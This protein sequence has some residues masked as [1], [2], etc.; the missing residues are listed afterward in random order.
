MSA[1]QD[2]TKKREKK[3]QAMREYRR[4][5]P[6]YKLAQCR[7]SHISRLRDKYLCW[8]HYTKGKFVCECCGEEIYFFFTNDHID[9]MGAKHRREINVYG[10]GNFTQWLRIHNFPPGI[11]ILCWNCQMGKKSF[12][13]VCPHKFF[14]KIKRFTIPED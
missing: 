14:D 7:Q 5:N 8:K 9:N 6:G 11:Q 4:K 1:P 3:A 12:D 13:G 10:S 2:L